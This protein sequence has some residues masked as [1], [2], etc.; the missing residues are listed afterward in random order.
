MFALF[1]LFVQIKI[2]IIFEK[3]I[4]ILIIEVRNF[5]VLTTLNNLKSN[6]NNLNIESRDL[7]KNNKSKKKI[8]KQKIKLLSCYIFIN[9]TI[10]CFEY[11][12]NIKF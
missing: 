3:K 12:T 6:K 4:V 2:A 11:L 5:V 1:F 8:C 7:C 9:K 10:T